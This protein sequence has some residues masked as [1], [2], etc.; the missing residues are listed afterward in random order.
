MCIT[1]VQTDR[2]YNKSNIRWKI[3]R[4]SCDGTIRSDNVGSCTWKFG[5][6]NTARDY[7]KKCAVLTT[8]SKSDIGFHVLA[9]REEARKLMRH[10]YSFSYESVIIAKVEVSGFIAR[11][12][13]NDMTS[14]RCE[15]WKHATLIDT[16]R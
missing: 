8:K 16:S 12:Y 3:L 7:S 1:N 5:V 13:L 2:P 15:T 14:F 10:L 6:K 4:K 11:G 9:T